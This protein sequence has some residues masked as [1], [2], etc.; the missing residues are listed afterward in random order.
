MRGNQNLKP[1]LYRPLF[2]E[3]QLITSLDPA[4]AIYGRFRFVV[5]TYNELIKRCSFGAMPNNF[6][7]ILKMIEY[8]RSI[9]ML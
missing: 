8:C 3:I 2:V 4:S 6:I 1:Y 5:I 9:P 7:E